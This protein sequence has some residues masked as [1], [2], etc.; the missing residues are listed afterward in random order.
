M[1]V[2]AITKLFKTLGD[3]TRLRL[4]RLMGEAEVSVMEMA[5]VTQL[6]QSRIS[7]HLKLL[8]EEGLVCE[9]RHGAW[10]Y[11]RVDEDR[12][13]EEARELWGPI[14][15]AWSNEGIFLADQERLKDVLSRR[16]GR[17]ELFFDQI[18]ERWDT[19][20]DEL[21]GDT[22]TRIILR[23]LLPPDV[24][25]ADIGCGTGYVM[26]MFGD[27]P[28]KIIA[29]DNNEAMLTVAKNKA[30]AH[31]WTN[32]EF[33]TGEASSPPLKEGEADL[34]TFV[35][36][37]HH[38][39]EPARAV[40][41]ASRALKPGGTL[42]AADLFEHQETWLR[43]RLKHR[44]LGFSRQDVEEWFAEAGLA[45]NA[46]SALPGRRAGQNGDLLSVPDG[47]AV[48]ATKAG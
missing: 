42:L 4:L 20:R 31:G 3:P 47:F 36:V 23:A 18:A 6:A 46:W 15:D 19:I 27:R 16:R 48:L 10:R 35:M 39:E 44:W 34:V 2:P 32:V 30:K 13:P 22:I 12:L 7:N 11:Y 14:R 38:L 1:D 28:R 41:A 24:V 37:W 40:K 45:P 33:R 25:V 43:E 9:R 26:D 8:R 17:D 21:F 29:I 5:E